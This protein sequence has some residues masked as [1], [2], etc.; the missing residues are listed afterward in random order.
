MIGIIIIISSSS[1]INIAFIYI[2]LIQHTFVYAPIFTLY[3]FYSLLHFYSS[4]IIILL[5]K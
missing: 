4:E 1:S 3:L 2:L 5:P